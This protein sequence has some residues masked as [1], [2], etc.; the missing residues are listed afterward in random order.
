ME[1]LNPNHNAFMVSIKMI[2]AQ[3]KRVMIDI[4][5]STNILYFDVFQK[6]GLL[7][8]DISPMVPSLMGFMSDSICLLGTTSLHIIFGEEPCSKIVMTKFIVIDILSAYNTI[9]G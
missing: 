4:D 6:L 9:V 2:N 1:Y 5:S 7:A 8:N 3:V